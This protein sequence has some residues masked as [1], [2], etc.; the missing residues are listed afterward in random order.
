MRKIWLICMI[1]L[2]GLMSACE[3]EK[4]V[5]RP[6]PVVG[7]YPLTVGSFWKYSSKHAWL[8]YDLAKE[9][10]ALDTAQGHI[11]AF[12][13]RYLWTYS[14]H[15]TTRNQAEWFTYEALVGTEVR[16]LYDLQDTSCYD[17]ILTLPIRVGDFWQR[18]PEQRDSVMEISVY[19]DSVTAMEAVVTPAG[20]FD[21][22]FR[23]TRISLW[24]SLGYLHQ[25]KWL[26]PQVGFV[27]YWNPPGAFGLTYSLE[28]YE[29]IAK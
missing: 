29:I 2:L 18:P 11:E 5:F 17:I 8:R 14:F 26:K 1:G 28:D 13:I 16:E 24:D 25:E 10:V 27:R 22:C 23:I 7:Y 12:K 4:H 21:D 15:D 6:E 9:V 20:D 19:Y 3:R